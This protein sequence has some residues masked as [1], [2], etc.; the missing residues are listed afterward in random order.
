MID[1]IHL[2]SFLLGSLI[3]YW[4][5]VHDRV[6][7]LVKF[8]PSVV[9]NSENDDGDTHVYPLIQMGAFSIDQEHRLLTEILA[10]Q[11]KYGFWTLHFR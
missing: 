8:S 7:K 5:M 1:V 9:G 2:T 11:V 6:F 3:S 4:D 10:S